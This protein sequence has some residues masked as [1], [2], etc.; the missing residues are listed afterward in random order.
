LRAV[1]VAL[2][3]AAVAAPA[4][5]ALTPDRWA[6]LDRTEVDAIAR[7]GAAEYT[8]AGAGPVSPVLIRHYWRRHES[9]VIKADFTC[10][11]GHYPTIVVWR[12]D[13]A[14]RPNSS[15]FMCRGA[16]GHQVV[17]RELSVC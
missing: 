13:R 16:R 10:A 5:T 8:K 7:A 11:G 4:A 2:G 17:C 9:W 6:G 3:A 15:S 12:A 1:A 14:F